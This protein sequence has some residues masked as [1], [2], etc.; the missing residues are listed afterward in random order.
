MDTVNYL[1]NWLLT[2]D[3]TIILEKAWI[4]TW[5][6]LKPIQIFG[7]KMSMYILS[8]KCSKSDVFKKWNRIF[9]GYTDTTKHFRVWAPKTH[10]V[11]N[12]SKPVVIK[13][14]R[15][16][17]LFAENLMPAPPRPFQLPTKEPKLQERFR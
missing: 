14:K 15:G 11:L 4:G 17:D 9:I 7:S 3:K 12:T 13:L 10:Q 8:K 16:T 2:T 5:P 6:N 1:W